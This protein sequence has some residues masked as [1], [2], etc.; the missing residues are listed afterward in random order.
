MIL[1]IPHTEAWTLKNAFSLKQF[2]AVYINLAFCVDA[3][4]EN[5]PCEQPI[6]LDQLTKQFNNSLI[7]CTEENKQSW[8]ITDSNTSYTEFSSFSGLSINNVKVYKEVKIFNNLSWDVTVSSSFMVVVI[9]PAVKC[10]C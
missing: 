6:I 4:K 2:R 9:P 1:L 10:S 7:N 5:V 8:F 3:N